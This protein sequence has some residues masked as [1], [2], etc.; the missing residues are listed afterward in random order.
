MSFHE[1]K[2]KQ[3]LHKSIDWTDLA[4]TLVWLSED[5]CHCLTLSTVGITLSPGL[6]TTE[7]FTVLRPHLG[8]QD[9]V[10]IGLLVFCLS[11]AYFFPYLE[12][13][14]F[15]QSKKLGLS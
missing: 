15:R 3:V 12:T 14:R 5:L 13:L 8:I 4:A 7:M 11:I 2:F 9:I 10:S 6:P 1:S